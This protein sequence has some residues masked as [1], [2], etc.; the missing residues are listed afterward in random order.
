M[1]EGDFASLH[2]SAD[3]DE[4]DLDLIGA[5]RRVG[6]VVDRLA[7]TQDFERLL[8]MVGGEAKWRRSELFTRLLT[9]RKR[10]QLP[11]LVRAS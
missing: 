8:E 5:Y 9:L 1:G 4:R 11:S 7:Y 6:V 3:L 2:A 10:G